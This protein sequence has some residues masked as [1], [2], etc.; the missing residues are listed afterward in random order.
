MLSF[1]K[2]TRGATSWTPRDLAKTLHLKPADARQAIAILEMQG[3]VKPSGS[4]GEWMTTPQGEIVS[5]S[6]LPRYSRDTVER[7]LDSFAEHLTR[8]NEDSTAPYKIADAVAFGDFL[9]GR[10]RVQA[11]DIG[12]RLAPRNPARDSSPPAAQ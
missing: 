7:S 10:A 4:K 1:L 9:S 6:K 11:P 2:E 8:V 3:Y 12:I 5:G